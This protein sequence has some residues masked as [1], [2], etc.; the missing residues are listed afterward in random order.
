M[1]SGETG[2]TIFK[3]LVGGTELGDFQKQR[4]HISRSFSSDTC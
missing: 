3:L 1:V 2:K 4:F